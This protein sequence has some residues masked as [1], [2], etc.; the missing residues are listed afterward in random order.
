MAPVEL[1]E[2]NIQLQESQSKR[3]IQPS[4]LPWGALVL[5]VKKKDGSCDHGLCDRIAKNS[6]NFQNSIGMAPY[7]ALYGR[8]CRSPMCWMESGEA[9]LIGPEMV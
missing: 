9:S 6:P 7:E 8:P 2:L 5:F 1:K 3:F 4:T